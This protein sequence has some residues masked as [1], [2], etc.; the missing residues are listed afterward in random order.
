V[1]D[2]GNRTGGKQ[3]YATGL[4]DTCH[5]EPNE[6]V[7]GRR[8]VTGEAGVSVRARD[9][10]S[11]NGVTGI[12]ARHPGR[13]ESRRQTWQSANGQ[14]PR[15]QLGKR[16]ANGQSVPIKKPFADGA[17]ICKGRFATHSAQAGQDLKAERVWDVPT[18]TFIIS[19]PTPRNTPEQDS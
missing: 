4:G 1:S 13:Q 14:A 9:T 2:Q 19:P 8:F 6:D 12:E 11:R 18:N 10:A 7:L 5:A 17:G 3:G 16:R 15:E